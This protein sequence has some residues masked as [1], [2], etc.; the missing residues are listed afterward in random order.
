MIKLGVIGTSKKRNERRI[1]IH[2]NHLKRIPLE[3]R[4]QLI[5]EKGYGKPF[6]IPDTEIAAL[7]SGRTMDREKLLSDIGNVIVAKPVVSDL[8]SLRKVGLL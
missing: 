6:D 1:P 8:Q 5:F 2:P 4:R 7:S 3:L